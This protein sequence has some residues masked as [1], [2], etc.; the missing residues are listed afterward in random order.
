MTGMDGVFRIE[1]SRM[2]LFWWYQVEKEDN[3]NTV[4]V[5]ID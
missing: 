2:G 1:A 5:V 4:E 3:L